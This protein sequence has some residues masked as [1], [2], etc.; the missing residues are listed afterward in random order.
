MKS[1]S[2]DYQVQEN[3]GKIEILKPMW[4]FP[5]SLTTS[6]WFPM[7]EYGFLWE[8]CSIQTVP[9]WAYVGNDMSSFLK[10]FHLQVASTW[11][12]GL[13]HG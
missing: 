12:S 13:G 6:K 7:C 1:V 3:F 9:F 4:K 10:K 11:T 2:N 5:V 8:A